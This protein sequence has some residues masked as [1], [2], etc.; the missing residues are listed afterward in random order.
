M[1]QHLYSLIGFWILLSVSGCACNAFADASSNPSQPEP[2]SGLLFEPYQM[3]FQGQLKEFDITF[4]DPFPWASEQNGRTFLTDF[5]FVNRDNESEEF[6]DIQFLYN[7]S[8]GSSIH[9]T[10]QASTRADTDT[11]RLLVIEVAYEKEG[12]PQQTFAG[13]ERFWVLPREG[14]DGGT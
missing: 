9:T 11:W 13:A 2:R 7:Y 5:R 6:S 1:V 4:K 12:Q 14:Q 8:G 3:I 10:L